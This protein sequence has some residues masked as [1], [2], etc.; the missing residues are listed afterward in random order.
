ML[1]QKSKLQLRR[2]G[3]GRPGS[4][5]QRFIRRDFA[6]GENGRSNGFVIESPDSGS[7]LFGCLHRDVTETAQLRAGSIHHDMDVRHVAVRG[8]QIYHIRL[9]GERSQRVHI[10]FGIQNKGF[11]SFS[12]AG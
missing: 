4:A 8:K 9:R 5:C 2:E 10:N 7:C 12:F 3:S 6:E 1:I 11:N